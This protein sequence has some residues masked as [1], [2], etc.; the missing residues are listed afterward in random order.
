[1]QTDERQLRLHAFIGAAWYERR[2][3]LGQDDRTGKCAWTRVM[4]GEIYRNKNGMCRQL[5]L[6]DV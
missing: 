3:R 2:R 5:A 4:D 6:V 1:M